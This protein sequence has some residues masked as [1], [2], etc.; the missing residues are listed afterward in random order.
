MNAKSWILSHVSTVY[1][2]KVIA[3]VLEYHKLFVVKKVQT[4]AVCK[5]LPLV[6]DLNIL[7][8]LNIF[9]LPKK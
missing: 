3:H 9:P 1:G 7:S 5:L 2:P 4:M 8:S 6:A